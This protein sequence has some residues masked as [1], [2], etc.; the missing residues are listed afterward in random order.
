[1]DA[2]KMQLNKR[3]LLPQ[4]MLLSLVL[5]G[6][7]YLGFNT[8]ENLKRQ[9]V[10]SGF[11]FLFTT[12]G[13]PIIQSLI[14]YT[15]ESTYLDA[16]WVGLINTFVVST[17]GI[18]TATIIGF[19]VGIARLSKNFLIRK[20]ADFYVETLRNIPLLIHIFFGYVVVLG[21]MPV[22]RNAH[23]F[24]DLV[25]ITN[26][27]IYFPALNFQGA[28]FT[29]Y[30]L[31]LIVI[32]ILSAGHWIA[33]KRPSLRKGLG[34]ATLLALIASCWVGLRG[35]QVSVPELAGF[36]FKGGIQ[37]IPELLALY[38]ALSIYTASFIAE[39]VRAGILA[40]P[41]GQTEAGQALGLSGWDVTKSVI[42]PQAMRIIVPP[43]SSQYLNL[44]KNSSLA[45]IIGYPDLVQVFAGTVLNQTGQAVEIMFMTM[46]VYLGVSLAISGFM[47]WFNSHVA[48]VER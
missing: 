6:V 18:A 3:Q 31:F 40:V 25:F 26:R 10:A 14:D 37:F 45:A 1:M 11:G 34:V 28:S 39:I 12:S 8:F 29:G 2:P 43:L 23:N 17:A 35:A 9:G 15:E 19:L 48:I 38:L 44:F 24:F 27:G 5:G 16:F 22:P 36:N 7:F 42:I 32:V 21:S 33:K 41:K 4:L 13:F 47:N 46:C 20:T 30:G